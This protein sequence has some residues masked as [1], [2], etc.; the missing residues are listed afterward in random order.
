M[1]EREKSVN[2]LKI[3]FISNKNFRFRIIR[4]KREKINK[5]KIHKKIKKL[6]KSF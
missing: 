5:K 3:I 4:E 1:L 2:L 6:F